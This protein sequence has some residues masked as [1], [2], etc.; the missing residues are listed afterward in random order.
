MADTQPGDIEGLVQ[1]FGRHLRALN[2]SPRTREK[3]V[4]AATQLA[5]YMA[6]EGGPV[7]VADIRRRDVEGYITHLLDAFT[8]GTALTRYQDLQQFFKWLVDEEE[9]PTS[10]MAKM[11]PPHLPDV[12]VP[13]ITDEQLKAL[14][15]TCDG[16]GFDHLRDQA[17]LRLFL[18]S[19]MRLSELAGLAVADIDFDDEIAVVM[20]KGSR[21][22][23]CPFGGKTARTLDRYLRARA[24]HRLADIPGLWLTRFGQMSDSAIGQMVRRRGN[25]AGIEGL[26][27]HI[28]RHTFAH[29]WLSQGGNEGDLM[30]LAGWRSRTMLGRYAA[31]TA[32]E[33][34][35][36]AHKRMRL[37]DRL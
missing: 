12:P 2:R 36:D 30:R 14:L 9:I 19:G 10:P 1:S 7:N 20:G 24:R 35:R 31:S 18:D 6:A 28:F 13:V 25:Q 3:Y 37:G 26:H 5:R 21:P 29:G 34:A 11:A 16:K 32:D 33:R 27:A 8:P 23:A 17:I 22:R 15:A 4:M